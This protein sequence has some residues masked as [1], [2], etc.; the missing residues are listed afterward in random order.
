MARPRPL[1]QTSKALFDTLIQGLVLR[2]KVDNAAGTYMAVHVAQLGDRLYSV[3]HQYEQN[4]DVMM[5]PEVHFYVAPSGEV[6]PCMY[7]L[8]GTGCR[9]ESL[10]VENGKVVFKPRAQRDVASFVNSTWFP[11]IRRQQ[12]LKVR[13][14]STS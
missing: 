1:T 14:D 12:G 4:G 7:R 11:N 9:V 5:D 6:F 8:D 10:W 2:R 13:R 3:S